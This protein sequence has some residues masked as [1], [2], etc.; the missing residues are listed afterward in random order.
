MF[1]PLIQSQ[2]VSPDFLIED[3]SLVIWIQFFRGV[4]PPG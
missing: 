1:L 3:F 4:A 2:I